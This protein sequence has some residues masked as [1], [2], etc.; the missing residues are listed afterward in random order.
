MSENIR[1]AYAIQSKY[2]TKNGEIETLYKCSECDTSVSKEQ[3]H[4]SKCY[5][6]IFWE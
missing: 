2:L 6:I 1:K 3:K 5:R 4:C